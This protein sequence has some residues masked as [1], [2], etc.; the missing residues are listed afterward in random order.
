MHMPSIVVIPDQ[1][2]N[3]PQ[4]P[5]QIQ[6][7]PQGQQQ[8]QQPMQLMTASLIAL[9]LM[10]V[11]ALFVFFATRGNSPQAQSSTTPPNAANAD[12]SINTTEPTVNPIPQPIDPVTP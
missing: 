10:A 11:T 6:I 1:N 2:Q 4:P 9:L 3:P 7:P 12:G 5:T 8:Q